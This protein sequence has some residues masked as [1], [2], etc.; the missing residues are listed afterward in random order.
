MKFQTAMIWLLT[1]I[2]IGGGA[3]AYQVHR[4][5]L[6]AA[7]A[8]AAATAELDSLKVAI[9]KDADVIHQDA[10]HSKGIID[11]CQESQ[12][13]NGSATL[14]MDSNHLIGKYAMQKFGGRIPLL[15]QVGIEWVVPGNVVPRSVDGVASAIY[16]F[17]DDNGNIGDWRI[18]SGVPQ[19]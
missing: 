11:A 13:E 4:L 5:R 14:M 10:M 9:A 1:G 19:P 3:G 2:A 12:G 7:T 15:Y 18:A 8:S 6:D 16:A 17:R